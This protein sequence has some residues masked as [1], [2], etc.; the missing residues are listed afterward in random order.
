MAAVVVANCGYEKKLRNTLSY[1]RDISDT[2]QQ[3]HVLS[4]TVY[5]PLIYQELRVLFHC[6][7]NTSVD[8]R[9][10]ALWTQHQTARPR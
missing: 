8:V 2:V 3:G 6:Q 7:T 5:V 9:T 10:P 1:L 4:S